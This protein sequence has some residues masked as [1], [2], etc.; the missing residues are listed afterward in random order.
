MPMTVPADP[1]R[2]MLAL[3][4]CAA[5]NSPHD[6]PVKARPVRSR[7]CAHRLMLERLSHGLVRLII[8]P[9]RWNWGAVDKYQAHLPI[10]S[11]GQAR[12]ISSHSG[13][14][15]AQGRTAGVSIGIPRARD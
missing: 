14:A 1:I 3:P 13:D 2:S 7:T 6:A 10:G 5:T 4:T 8:W 9:P 11:L 15:S 12:R